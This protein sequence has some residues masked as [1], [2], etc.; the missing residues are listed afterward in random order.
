MD[1]LSLVSIEILE[2]KLLEKRC[3]QRKLALSVSARVIKYS[4]MSMHSQFH[5]GGVS[6]LCLALVLKC[7]GR[8]KCQRRSP[9]R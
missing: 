2:K 5:R 1:Q 4:M 6:W 7:R 3:I 8:Q 9:L